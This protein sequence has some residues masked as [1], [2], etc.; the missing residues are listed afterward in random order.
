MVLGIF[1]VVVGCG[2]YILG[3]DGWWR[4]YFVWW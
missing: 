4:V 3:S 1:W 2:A